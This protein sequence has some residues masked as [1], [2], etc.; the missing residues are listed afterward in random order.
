MLTFVLALI[1]VGLSFR[2]GG[3]AGSR[4]HHA[5]TN[6]EKRTFAIVSGVLQVIGVIAAVICVTVAY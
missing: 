3:A 6:D 5:T 4:M 1:I 2:Y